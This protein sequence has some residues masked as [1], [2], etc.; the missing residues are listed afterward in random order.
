MLVSTKI[1]VAWVLI[2]IG[3]IVLAISALA[4][5][6]NLGRPGFGIV[7]I[8]GIVLGLV[9]AGIGALLQRQSVA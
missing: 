3:V 2:V 4:D 9:I 1:I 8:L 7:Q 6:F 5:V